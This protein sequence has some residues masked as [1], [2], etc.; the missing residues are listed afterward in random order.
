MLSAEYFHHRG[1]MMAIGG[2]NM[3]SGKFDDA[4]IIQVGT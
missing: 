2:A 4:E 3:G 1:K